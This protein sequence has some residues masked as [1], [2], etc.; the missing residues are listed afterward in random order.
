MPYA[1]ILD[2]IERLT[3]K[4]DT[5]EESKHWARQLADEILDEGERIRALVLLQKWNSVEKKPHP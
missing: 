4:E 3:Q 2:V 5:D 1:R